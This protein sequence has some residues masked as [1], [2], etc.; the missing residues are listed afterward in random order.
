ML[1]TIHQLLGSP[2]SEQRRQLPPLGLEPPLNVPVLHEQ[3]VHYNRAGQHD[4]E[5]HR[6]EPRIGGEHLTPQLLRH[7]ALV[8]DLADGSVQDVNRER[9]GAEV[10]QPL[11]AQRLGE[12]IVPGLTRIRQ[13]R[14][15]RLPVHAHDERGEQRDEQQPAGQRVVQRQPPE[16]PAN[17]DAGHA[18]QR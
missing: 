12:R 2:S 5:V 7:H 8:K 1:Q 10:R 15:H 9:D 18:Q 4:A 6:E 17:D 3:L 14:V 13:V 11:G 16:R